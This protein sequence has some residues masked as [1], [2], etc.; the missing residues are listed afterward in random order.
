M[1]PWT[2]LRAVRLDSDDFTETYSGFTSRLVTDPNTGHMRF[3]PM[4]PDALLDQYYN[5]TFTRSE[6]QPNPEKEFT[7]QILG[8]M[9]ELKGYLQ[10][11]GGLKDG[12]TFHDVGCGFGATVWSM[13]QLGVRATGNEANRSWIET[14]NPHCG[15]KLSSEPLD[16]VLSALPYKVDAFFCAHVLEHVTDPL[17][18]LKLMSA[19]LSN[20][21][22]AYL[23]MPNIHNVRTIRRGI[24]DSGAYAFP[25]HLSYFTPKSLVAM[26]REAGLEPVQIE[27]RSMFEDEATPQDCE[28]L[29]GWELFMLAVKPGN[30][31]AKRQLDID[32]KCAEA[33]RYFNEAFR[34]GYL[35]QKAAA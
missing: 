6:D 9:R 7:P 20:E 26:V 32:G 17:F 13:L 2:K 3:D 35:K 29:R 21:G 25:M 11:V 27:T 1:A 18:L 14:A 15:G 8:V 10:D 19:H 5:G 30:T 16:Q 28:K 33:F 22:V 23:C 4:P 34:A 31:L 12:F 24:R